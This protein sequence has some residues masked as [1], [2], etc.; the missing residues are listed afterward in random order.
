MAF[1][2]PPPPSGGGAWAKKSDDLARR[3]TQRADPSVPR[4]T[5]LHDPPRT[6]QQYEQDSYARRSCSMG[7]CKAGRHEY[8][9]SWPSH[10]IFDKN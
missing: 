3:K 8:T 10:Y 6:E 5:P 1:R 4:S 2:G 9:Y 7:R